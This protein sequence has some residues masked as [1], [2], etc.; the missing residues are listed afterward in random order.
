M[1]Y[2]FLDNQAISSWKKYVPV[3][4]VLIGWARPRLT[5]CSRCRS[6]S[7][8]KAFFSVR[9][10]TASP[11]SVRTLDWRDGWLCAFGSLGWLVAAQEMDDQNCFGMW[12]VEHSGGYRC[13]HGMSSFFFVESFFFF[14]FLLPLAWGS[15][16]MFSLWNSVKS[17]SINP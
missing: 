9:A 6:F 13:L 10:F 4:E 17:H 15:A 14:S 16:L 11:S 5:S 8:S 7:S 1:G 12:E 2:H 3:G